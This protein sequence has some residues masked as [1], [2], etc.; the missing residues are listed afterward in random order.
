M[1][2]YST[3]GKY[4]Q[5]MKDNYPDISTD[6]TTGMTADGTDSKERNYVA[7]MYQR[8]V[9]NGYDL[10]EGTAFYDQVYGRGT[11]DIGSTGMQ[12]M[13]LACAQLD[14][15]QRSGQI[16]METYTTMMVDMISPENIENMSNYN[17]DSFMDM[18]NKIDDLQ[19]AGLAMNKDQR[20]DNVK[21]NKAALAVETR[22]VI[23][24]RNDYLESARAARSGAEVPD[25]TT[26]YTDMV[27]MLNKAKEDKYLDDAAYKD[28]LD[29]LNKFDNVGGFTVNDTDREAM[30]YAMQDS[31]ATGD[32][33]LIGKV[34]SKD[35]FE[36]IGS[37]TF[38]NGKD[39]NAIPILREL[40]DAKVRGAVSVDAG[41]RGKE[42]PSEE[43]GKN[44][45]GVKGVVTGITGGVA[46]MVDRLQRPKVEMDGAEIR[47]ITDQM[48]SNYFENQG[49]D[50]ISAVEYG[51][52]K[53]AYEEIDPNDYE[54]RRKF[55]EENPAFAEADDYMTKLDQLEEGVASGRFEI[56]AE[57]DGSYGIRYNE[58]ADRDYDT[59]VKTGQWPSGVQP[60]PGDFKLP[61]GFDPFKTNPQLL[62]NDALQPRDATQGLDI[63][64]WRQDFL[65]DF[66]PPVNFDDDFIKDMNKAADDLTAED[67]KNKEVDAG[68][69]TEDQQDRS[70]ESDED[71]KEIAEPDTDYDA[72][73]GEDDI[74]LMMEQSP[75]EKFE[76][77]RDA[78]Q[79]VWAGELGNGQARVDALTEMGFDEE[80]R[81]RIQAMVDRG[82][83]WCQQVTPESYDKAFPSSEGTLEQREAT[84]RSEQADAASRLMTYE[85]YGDM[86]AAYNAGV[87]EGM[88]ITEEQA[89]EIYD[90]AAHV[91]DE[92]WGSRDPD[93]IS[94]E[95]SDESMKN[96]AGYISANP[97]AEFESFVSDEGK[98]MQVAGEDTLT[99]EGAEASASDEMQV[100]G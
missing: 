4:I 85:G 94:A 27:N 69:R 1:A 26:M 62:V 42:E 56:C 6:T 76:A 13:A 93:S 17:Y 15:M 68:E 16:D 9:D 84:F 52:M 63:M 60:L 99:Y 39:A 37:M 3:I 78:A 46:V 14:S 50:G 31:L 83:K 86:M 54:A 10:G 53:S 5:G 71:S 79:A 7:Q 36:S 20:D 73:F 44:T 77:M 35:G 57:K 82:D 67:E 29:A 87:E 25:R 21:A 58:K 34:M 72:E 49:E 40:E 74:A 75:M 92:T 59:F 66:V 100:G 89:A 28:A 98:V 41:E 32:K 91:L 38:W 30:Y 96:L 2:K 64:V 19:T 33:D 97:D 70:A 24:D 90:K 23:N 95:E 18:T 47:Q 22:P 88:G 12:A 65:K 11:V 51:R 48:A 8:L 81:K 80:S 43:T 45:D 55:R 61:E